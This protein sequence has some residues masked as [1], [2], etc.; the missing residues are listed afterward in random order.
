MAGTV[1]VGGMNTEITLDGSQPVRTLRELRQAV[2]NATSA[3]KAEIDE[4][5]NV[6]KSSE[7]SKDK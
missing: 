7:M 1:P 6:G 4:M 5:K 3:W 2:T